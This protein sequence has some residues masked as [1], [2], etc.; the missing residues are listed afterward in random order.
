MGEGGG[1]WGSGRRRRPRR[2]PSS[3][4][5][6]GGA[7]CTSP[8]AAGG[9]RGVGGGGGGLVGEFGEPG[10]D[11]LVVAGLPGV[12]AADPLGVR[13]DLDECG[14]EPV[15]RSVRLHDGSSSSSQG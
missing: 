1:G 2:T 7:G 9:G 4:Q 12:E 5:P 3:P 13:G 6:G 15:V 14:G 8:S 11:G 10:R